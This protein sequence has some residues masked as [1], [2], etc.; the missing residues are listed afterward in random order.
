M[1]LERA[2]RIVKGAPW[3]VLADDAHVWV[4]TERFRTPMDRLARAFHVYHTP[5]YIRALYPQAEILPPANRETQ[6]CC[7]IRKNGFAP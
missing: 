6:H 4:A 7:V 3:F 5:S 1:D 2:A